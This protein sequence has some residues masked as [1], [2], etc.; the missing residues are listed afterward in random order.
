[1]GQGHEQTGNQDWHVIRGS[2]V[3]TSHIVVYVVDDDAPVRAALSRVLRSAGFTVRDYGCS[4]R[5]LE[6][7]TNGDDACVV[8]DLTMPEMSGNDVQAQLTRQGIRVP[9][10]ALSAMDDPL[11]R[12]RAKTLGAVMLLRKPVDDQALFDAISWA[13]DPHRAP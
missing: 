13:V 11:T 4:R 10:I 9:V 7:V 5:F 12:E 3:T 2:A 6:E 8:L 1:M